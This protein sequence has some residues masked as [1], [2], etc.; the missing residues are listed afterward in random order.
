MVV[1]KK[2]TS[3]KK[4]KDNTLPVLTHLLGLVTGFL[5]PLIML[6]ALDDEKVKNHSRLAL[7]WHFSLMIYVFCSFIL[8]LVLIGVLTFLILIVLN[9]VFCIIATIKASD[10]NYWKYPLAIPFFKVEI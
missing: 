10:G 8:M 9:F 7:N 5:G 6:L 3:V 2:S 1:K 4:S